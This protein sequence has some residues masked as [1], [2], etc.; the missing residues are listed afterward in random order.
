M[1]DIILNDHSIV[2]FHRHPVGFHAS[3]V[4]ELARPLQEAYG[5]KHFSHVRRARCGRVSL[6]S[7]TPGVTED[8]I[9]D[10]LY[11]FGLA[12]DWSAYHSGD[13][14]LDFFKPSE[15]NNILIASRERYGL[16]HHFVMIRKQAKHC[17]FFYFAASADCQNINEVYL[18]HRPVFYSFVEYFQERAASMIREADQYG[19]F[20]P[21]TVVCPLVQ[22]VGG[23]FLEKEAR[24][25]FN[26]FE[27]NFSLLS[28]RER[29]CLACFLKFISFKEASF[30]LSISLRTFEKHMMSIRN[31]LGCSN[32]HELYVKFASLISFLVFEGQT[33][34]D[35]Q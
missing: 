14:I 8:Y 30:R 24:L 5:I 22:A 2:S 6:L 9:N 32:S 1:S 7:N 28:S 10:R 15:L 31:K 35:D 18:N 21:S 11:R 12:G 34:H 26:F 4:S 29:E 23:I 3:S 17:D 13:Y 19:I 16:D 27:E 25:F 20:F 33:C